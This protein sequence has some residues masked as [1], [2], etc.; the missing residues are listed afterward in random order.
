MKRAHKSL[1]VRATIATLSILLFLALGAGLLLFRSEPIGGFRNTSFL[2]QGSAQRAAASGPLRLNA[3]NRLYFTDA[4]GKAVYLTGSH[5]WNNLQDADPLFV[6]NLE[7]RLIDPAPKVYPKFDFAEH[8]RFLI[9]EN[10]NFTRLWTCEQAAWVPW[11]VRKQTIEPLPYARTGPGIALDG[12]PKFD[13]TKFDQGYF[14]RMRSRVSAAGENGIYVAV[15]L[16]NGWSIET[17]GWQPGTKVWRGHPFNSANNINGID[18]DPNGDEEGSE[19]HSLALPQVVAVQKAY[20]RK[21]IETLN[22]L[23]NVLWEISNESPGTAK[24]WQYHMINFVKRS[25]AELPKQHPVGMTPLYQGGEN[26]DLFNS[27]ADWIS[28]GS[29]CRGDYCDDPP[30]GDGSKV[31]IIDTDHLGGLR[32]NRAWVWKSFTRGLNPIFMDPVEMPEWESIRQ[33]MGATLAYARRMNLAAMKS[34]SELSST[35]YC[36]ADPG[37]EYLIYAPGDSAF[38]DSVRFVR[39]F[40]HQI[41][42][43]CRIFRRKFTVDLSPHPTP[44]YVEWLNATTGETNIGG[45]V[46]GGAKV[47]FTA[48]FRGDAVLYL[49]RES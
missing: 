6:N 22:D 15:M 1:M 37:N 48:P 34:H 18:G 31:I 38:I 27:P 43:A 20:V 24:E 36:L 25:E 47:T 7:G 46:K 4:K 39:R 32:R 26:A 23:D 16:F 11:L 2:A 14:D 28:P 12:N 13:L 29:Y 42:H 3:T 19:A 40:K 33:A 5:N 49:R 44:F 45:S 8:I 35:R 10:H 9:R 41:R 21:V 30:P 17:K